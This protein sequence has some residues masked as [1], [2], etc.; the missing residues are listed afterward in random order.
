MYWLDN[1]EKNL[2]NSTLFGKHTS[3]TKC[4]LKFTHEA[5]NNYDYGTITLLR[6]NKTTIEMVFGFLSKIH[7][8]DES[9]DEKFFTLTNIV[10]VYW[11]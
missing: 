3:F 10:F 11:D 2:Y 8:D 9:S 6:K 4:I 1:A 5:F 7:I